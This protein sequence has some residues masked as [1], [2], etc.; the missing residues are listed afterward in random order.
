MPKSAPRPCNYPGC[1]VLVHG[2]S[3][4]CEQHKYKRIEAKALDARRGSSSERGYSYKWQ[5][6]REGF[7][8]AHPLCVR[9]Q[10]RGEVVAATVVDHITP[11]KGDKTLFWQRANWQ[12]LCKQCHDIK[13]AIEDGGFGRSVAAPAA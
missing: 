10:A 5:Q 4:R 8:R 9:H 13:T 3:S 2:G 6:A 12:P 1:G 7:L 11:H